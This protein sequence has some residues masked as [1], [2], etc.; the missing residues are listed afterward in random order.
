MARYGRTVIIIALLLAVGWDVWPRLWAPTG[1][2]KHYVHLARAFLHGRLDIDEPFGDVATFNGKHYVVFP[3]FPAV[4]ITPLVAIFGDEARTTVVSL[5]LT[6]LSF[7]VLRSILRKMEVDPELRVWLLAGFFLGTAYTTSLFRAYESWHFAHMVA[8]ACLLLAIREAMGR[9]RT[10]LVGLCC[11]L[12]FLSRHLCVY[13]AIFPAVLLWQHRRHLSVPRQ[14]LHGVGFALPLALCAGVYLYL[15]WVR[16]G[17]PLETGY[18]FMPLEGFLQERVNRYGLFHPAYVP[19]NLVHLLLQGFRIDFAPPMYLSVAEMD[20][21]GTSVTFASPFIFLA[22]LAR[23]DRPK[24]WAAWLAVTLAVV[25][26]LFYY[27]NGYAQTNAQRFTLDYL[28]ILMLL[29][30]LGAPRVRPIWWKAAIAY[31][32]TLNFTALFVVSLLQ[33]LTAAI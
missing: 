2:H 3:P 29:I 32:V 17:N 28:P 5:L 14:I 10:P 23:W 8:V 13:A 31:A 11:G 6:L 24:L 22:F 33:R 15:N 25:N 19:F 4:L 18:A 30:A 9:A 21:L 7:L 26:G 16:F 27:N 20:P 12:A 1:E